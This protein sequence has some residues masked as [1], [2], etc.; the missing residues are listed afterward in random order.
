MNVTVYEIFISLF[1]IP[2]MAFSDRVVE[3]GPA[4]FVLIDPFQTCG[5]RWTASDSARIQP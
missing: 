3:K 1:L 4:F 5:S 2:V